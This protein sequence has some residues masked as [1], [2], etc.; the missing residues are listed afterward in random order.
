MAGKG[1]ERGRVLGL[2]EQ[3]EAGRGDGGGT[4]PA[5]HNTQLG[6]GQCVAMG[7]LQAARVLSQLSFPGTCDGREGCP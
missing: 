2:G 5:V 1:Q 7:T 6:W 4:D 3:W